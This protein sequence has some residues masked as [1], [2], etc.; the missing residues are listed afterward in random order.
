MCLCNESGLPDCMLLDDPIPHSIYSEQTISISAVVVGQDWGTVAG[1]VHAQFLHKLHQRIY[2]LNLH[3]VFKVLI[4]IHAIRYITQ[5]SSRLN[6]YNE[7]LYSQLKIICASKQCNDH[8]LALDSLKFLYSSF[9][10]VAQTLNYSTNSAQNHMC[11][12][13]M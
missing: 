6:I 9:L 2:I 7:S 12:K 8:S 13:T 5:Y 1:S 3:K 10:S 11:I 4:N